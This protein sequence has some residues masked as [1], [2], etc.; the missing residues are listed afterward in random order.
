M[1]SGSS[2]SRT[3]GVNTSESA[4]SLWSNTSVFVVSRNS[5]SGYR[6]SGRSTP[7][8]SSQRSYTASYARNPTRPPSSI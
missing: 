5:A 8:S 6:E 2:S 1:A 4:S 7:T 3:T